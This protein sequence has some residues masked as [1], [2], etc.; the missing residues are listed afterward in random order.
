VLILYYRKKQKGA[1]SNNNNNT[2]ITRKIPQRRQSSIKDNM[3]I[4]VDIGIPPEGSKEW[5]T[6]LFRFHGF[7]NLPTTRGVSVSSP[8]FSCF[9]HQLALRLYPGGSNTSSE[10]FVAVQLVNKSNTS[11]KIQYGYSVRDAN[12]K[13][14]VHKAYV[15]NREFGPSNA[16]C[17][18]NFSKRSTIMN[19]LVGGSLVIELRMKTVSTDKS[20]TQFIP[21]NP[22]NKN[23]LKKFMD[24]ESA[25]VVFEVDNGCCWQCRGKGKAKSKTATTFHA[26]RFILND[27]STVLSELMRKPTE[28]G[29]ITTVSVTDLSP[30]IFKHML[31]DAYGGKLSDEDLK[32]NAKDIIYACDKYGFV[33][34]KLEAE[35]AYVKSI[36][37]TMDNMM[38]NLLYADSKNL[39]LL[40][41]AVMD[42]IVENKHSI[43][44]KVSFDNFPCHL[45]TDLLTAVARGEQPDAGEKEDECTKYNK[46][47]VGTLRKMLDEKGLDV[48]G[49]REAM[50][51]LLKEN[52]A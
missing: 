35:A 28:S 8:N 33:H 6:A 4:K 49:S 32:N 9:G 10:G 46:M 39:A 48:D 20:I 51:A 2:T 5:S 24:E 40:K 27:I 26:H 30:D 31:Y 22:I 25:D 47:R 21:S 15:D 18:K 38:D 43:I 7:A 14:V 36:E 41:E 3:S 44:G 45:V 50:I 23:V 12:G 17:F 37:I 34:L 29:G 11:I 52:S 19:S 1:P 16:R 42:Y 13:E